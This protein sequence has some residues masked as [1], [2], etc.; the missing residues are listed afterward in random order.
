[1]RRRTPE[2]GDQSD[3]SPIRWS[4]FAASPCSG[5]REA[6]CVAFGVEEVLGEGAMFRRSAVALVG[7]VMVAGCGGSGDDGVTRSPVSSSMTTSLTATSSTSMPTTTASATT[8]TTTTTTTKLVEAADGCDR[9]LA[10]PGEYEAVNVVGDVEQAYWIVV[11][12]AYEDV[13]PAPLY[14]H[15]ASGS[16]D[17]N[18][19]LDGW[20]P[21]LDDVPGLM[22]MVNTSGPATRTTE[23]LLALADQVSSDYCV[24]PAR[25]HVLGTSSSFDLAE[26]LACEASDRIAS[27]VAALGR[28]SLECTPDRPVPLLSFSGD[29]DRTGVAAMVERWIGFNGCDPDPDVE[30]LGSGV[31][32][33]T[34]ESCEADVVFYDIEG[35]GHAWPLHEAKGPAAGYVEEYEEVDY[36]EEAFAFFAEHPMP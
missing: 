20:R 9:P 6:R 24:D 26:R 14:L 18:A 5:R 22:V 11:S 32:R 7:L 8:S 28:G 1:M 29:P 25:V 16:G 10:A 31:L 23:A 21:Y 34:Y 13:A 4:S 12:A 2:R 30:D 3:G 19:F 27:F 35:M 36:L 17:H 15:L 33:R